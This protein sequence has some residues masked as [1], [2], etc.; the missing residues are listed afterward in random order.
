LLAEGSDNRLSLHSTRHTW[1]TVARRARVPEADINEL[2]GWAGQ[3]SSSATYDH[4]LLETQLVETQRQIWE[5][6][7]RAGYLEKW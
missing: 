7:G 3:R 4:G 1:R 6:M 5:A 2:G